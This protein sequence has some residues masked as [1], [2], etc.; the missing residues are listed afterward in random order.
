MDAVKAKEKEMKEEKENAR[1][2]CKRQETQYNSLANS[3]DRREF[4]KLKTS[5]PKRKSKPNTKN[6]QRQC[7][8]K[9]L[10]G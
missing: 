10:R 4:R 1:V 2:V 7:T 9:E 8:G 6:W 5:E 3:S